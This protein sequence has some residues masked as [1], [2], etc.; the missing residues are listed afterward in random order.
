MPTLMAPATAWKIIKVHTATCVTHR[1]VKEQRGTKSM[2]GVA[3][4]Q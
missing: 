4:P 1:A 2:R 3:G